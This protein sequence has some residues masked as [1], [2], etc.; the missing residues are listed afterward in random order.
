[1]QRMEFQFETD[2]EDF[3]WRPYKGTNHHKGQGARAWDYKE[4]ISYDG[5]GTTV[6]E[7]TE[8]PM[9]PTVSMY[10]MTDDNNRGFGP[11]TFEHT[12]TAQPYVLLANS[13]GD[14][15]MAR[16]GLS[17]RACLEYL[18]D[19][20]AKYP[21]AIHCGFYLG[22]DI[23]QMLKDLTVKKQRSLLEKN[24]CTF[25]GRYFIKWL[26]RKTFFVKDRRTGRKI[27]LYDTGGYFQQSLIQV[28]EKYLGK[29]DPRLVRIKEGKERRDS[30]NWEE[31]EDF[32]IPYNDAEMEMHVDIMNIL[33][34]DLHDVGIDCGLWYGPG[35]LAN[36]LF[37]NWKIP[38]TREIPEEVLDAGQYAYAGG[39]FELFWMGRYNGTVYE[40]DIHS[41]YPA[42]ATLL[43]N[44]QRGTW[45]HTTSFEPGSFGV[46]HIDYRSPHE[47]WDIYRPQPLFCRARDGRITY[48]REVTGWYWTPEAELVADY[49]QEGWIFRE[50]DP[51]DRP[52][53]P[54]KE[55]YVQRLVLKGE[56]SSAEHAVKLI[57]NCIYG[58]MAQ[59][60]GSGDETKPPRWHQLEYAGFITSYTRAKIYRAIELA[61]DKILSTE[62]D[63][64]FSTVPLDLPLSDKL[65]D[66]EL[67]TFDWIIYMQSGFYYYPVGDTVKAKY[68]G[69]DKD[70]KT[71]HPL[72]LPL[73][74][75]EQALKKNKNA[76][77]G[78]TT[79]FVGMAL[80]LATKAI[81]RSWE[82]KDHI[83]RLSHLEPTLKRSHSKKDC[84]KC[85]KGDSLYDC[86]HPLVIGGYSG[87][88]YARALPWR[89]VK[90]DEREAYQLDWEEYLELYGE[91][92]VP[93]QD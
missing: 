25:A 50:D 81:W 77:H 33:R 57:L 93:W 3:H 14:R 2:D 55:K 31:L 37:T 67:K 42:A 64:V 62:T 32:I 71:G 16:D 70:K 6:V 61:P 56:R 59:V 60:I 38:I 49:V 43:P 12:A 9:S 21:N 87:Y 66:W 30:F 22:Y 4:F 28:A 48:P 41:A 75:V 5:E 73:K 54:V 79:R 68:R 13:K 86:L 11:I 24:R 40:Y 15:I 20:A 39:R 19:C 44:L 7:P 23:N 36:R 88:S 45:I 53:T 85:G 27:T 18:L 76:L 84:P 82:T 17:T 46:W 26:P 8:L 69:M 74:K 35:A 92:I 58:K 80:A 34:K 10:Q 91:R 63:A 65:G 78:K 29:D 83:I 89:S 52:F 72:G 1:M 90:S 47:D 51:S